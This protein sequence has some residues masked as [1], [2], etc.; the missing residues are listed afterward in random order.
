MEK[1][2]TCININLMDL[3][4]VTGILYDSMSYSK[5]LTAKKKFLDNYPCLLAALA[6][7]FHN[8]EF[9]VHTPET[10][11]VENECCACVVSRF[12]NLHH[13]IDYNVGTA[14]RD[15]MLQKYRYNREGTMGRNAKSGM[16]VAKQAPMDLTDDNNG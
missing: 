15:F 2:F 10:P 6:E 1:H 3:N 7:V 9:H 11:Q 14:A 4:K 5:E 13:K 12:Y 16:S 8:F